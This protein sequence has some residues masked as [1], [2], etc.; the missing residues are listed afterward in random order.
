MY[1]LKKLLDSPEISKVVKDAE[2][3]VKEIDTS[4]YTEQLSTDVTETLNPIDSLKGYLAD[5]INVVVGFL[6]LLLATIIVL[7][8][9]ILVD[10]PE[11]L[12]RTIPIGLLVTFVIVYYINSKLKQ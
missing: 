1:T 2:K 6:A 12:R 9:A 11:V 5:S 7:N 8:H 10:D 3:K 4:E